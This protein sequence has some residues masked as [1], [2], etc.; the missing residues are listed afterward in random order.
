MLVLA[1]VYKNLYYQNCNHTGTYIQYVNIYKKSMTVDFII[2]SSVIN[3]L[4]RALPFLLCTK[5]LGGTGHTF[6]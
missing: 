2:E 1:R 6:G 3:Q 4:L 5:Q